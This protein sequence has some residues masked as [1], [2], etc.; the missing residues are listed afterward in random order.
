MCAVILVSVHVKIC[1]SPNRKSCSGC[2]DR[3]N[4]VS[5]NQDDWEQPGREAP[6]KMMGRTETMDGVCMLTRDNGFSQ[7]AGPKQWEGWIP[8]L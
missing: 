1:D 4:S 5:P 6:S 2:R 3:E 7:A 8:H